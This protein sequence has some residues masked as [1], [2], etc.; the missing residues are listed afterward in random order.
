MNMLRL[1]LDTTA[2]LNHIGNASHMSIWE[3]YTP[4]HTMV[5]RILMMMKFEFRKR[6]TSREEIGL[7]AF[8]DAMGAIRPRIS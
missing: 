6:E 1:D 7:S 8:T 2:R 4:V 5:H 3:Y